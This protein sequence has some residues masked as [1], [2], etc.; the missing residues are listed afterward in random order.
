MTAPQ[1][2]ENMTYKLEGFIEKI[3]SPVVCIFGDTEAEYANGK[4]LYEQV[5][6]RY[7]LVDEIMV[8]NEKIVLRMIE[9]NQINISEDGV[10]FF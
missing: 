7:W 5:F 6:D 4:V 2:G 9:N 8:K 3:T 10:S 1:M